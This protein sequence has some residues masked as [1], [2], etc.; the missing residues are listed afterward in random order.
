MEDEIENMDMDWL[1]RNN[2]Y[3]FKLTEN[4][5]INFHFFYIKDKTIF[6]KQNECVELITPNFIS[7]EELL[8]QIKNNQCL[9]NENYS[10]VKINY[11]FFS[12]TCEDLKH[13]CTYPFAI[14][15]SPLPVVDSLSIPSSLDIFQDLNT[16]NIFYF[17]NKKDYRCKTKKHTLLTKKK[18]KK[19]I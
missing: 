3:N 7:A 12:Q 9:H 18:S 2:W 14:K 19:R 15:W 16:I 8:T 6:Y 13:I 4:K 10:L 17:A 5:F 1:D 11:H